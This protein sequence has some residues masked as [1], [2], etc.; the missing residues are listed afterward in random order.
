MPCHRG[1]PAVCPCPPPLPQTQEIGQSFTTT[2]PAFLFPSQHSSI[3]PKVWIILKIEETNTAL[4]MHT[5]NSMKMVRGI[6]WVSWTLLLFS[7]QCGWC[8]HHWRDKISLGSKWGRGQVHYR[9]ATSDNSLPPWLGGSCRSVSS[10]TCDWS[11]KNKTQEPICTCHSR[12]GTILFIVTL[13]Y[14]LLCL[15]GLEW[16]DMIGIRSAPER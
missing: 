10:R 7:C 4:H 14:L 11:F 6:H 1:L 13:L 5:F 15:D 16:W 3:H 12:H 2:I 9:N 8:T